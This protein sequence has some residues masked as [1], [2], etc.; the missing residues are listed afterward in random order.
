[1]TMGVLDPGY[2]N[3]RPSTVLGEEV[4]AG[5]RRKKEKYPT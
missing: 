1:M 2:A 4:T 3:S 5:E